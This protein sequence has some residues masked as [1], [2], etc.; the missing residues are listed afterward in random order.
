MESLKSILCIAAISVLI[1][2]YLKHGGEE[3]MDE[4][5]F[6]LGQRL[7]YWNYKFSLWKDTQKI[8][9]S[10]RYVVCKNCGIKNRIKK[11]SRS[12]VCCSCNQTIRQKQKGRKQ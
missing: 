10:Y 4:A 8:K 9:H 5:I 7:S 12:C 6:R 1:L 2:F 3:D 11:K